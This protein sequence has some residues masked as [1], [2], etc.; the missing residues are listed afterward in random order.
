MSKTYVMSECQRINAVKLTRACK[1]CVR[2]K[3]KCSL[4]FP[5][6]DRCV[7]REFS[8]IYENV[9]L[10]VRQFR[11]RTSTNASVGSRSDPL[12]RTEPSDQILE[13]GLIRRFP[14]LPCIVPVDA[15]TIE[16]MQRLARRHVVNFGTQ[17][18][19]VF[20]HN[21]IVAS[22]LTRSAQ[23]ICRQ[24]TSIACRRLVVELQVHEQLAY[25]MGALNVAAQC[26]PDVSQMLFC[27]QCLVLIQVICLFVLKLSSSHRNQAEK[28]QRLLYVWTR[29]LWLMAPSVLPSSLTQRQAFLLAESVRR[30]IIVSGEIQALYHAVK[31]GWIEH[32][33]FLDSLPFERR[34]WLW[35]V[36]DEKFSNCFVGE[37]QDI[38]SWREFVD[39]FDAG[40]VSTKMTSFETMLLV[41]AKSKPVVDAQ[42][43]ASR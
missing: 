28:R 34:A 25:L 36:P 6:C 8:C 24:S 29:K 19:N 40:L 43:K 33:I 26:A 20:I 18:A 10:N 7:S 9:P 5:S 30:T 32:N 22:Q 1:A 17:G 37:K 31:Y 27:V 2:A 21:D 11:G 13:P 3:R 16:F 23:A 15:E 4:S 12:D 38:I 35:E 14:M 39:L 41:G 42:L